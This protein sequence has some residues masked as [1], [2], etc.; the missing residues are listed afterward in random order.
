MNIY[1]SAGVVQASDDENGPFCT[2]FA[3][4]AS[5]SWFCGTSGTY[6]VSASHYYCGNFVS[7]GN[8]EYRSFTRACA[9]CAPADAALGNIGISLWRYNISGN[10]LDGGK[11]SG[12]FIGKAGSVYPFDLC[13]GAPGTGTADLDIDIKITD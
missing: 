2:G 8:M 7:S 13:P 10:C 1:N 5:I 12:S 3:G 6:Y 4:P 9:D 11:W